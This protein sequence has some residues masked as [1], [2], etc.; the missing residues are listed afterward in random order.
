MLRSKF[1]SQSKRL[2]D[3]LLHDNS[4]VQFGDRGDYVHIIQLAVMAVEPVSISKDELNSQHYGKTT[5]DAVLKYKTRRNIVNATYQ[6]NADAIV[7][8]MTIKALDDELV[9]REEE[10]NTQDN[11]CVGIRPFNRI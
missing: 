5:Q 10:E 11:V 1:L 3:C 4:H 2:Q 9:K 8:K 6:K 7:G